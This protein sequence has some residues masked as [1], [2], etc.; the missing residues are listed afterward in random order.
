MSRHHSLE[1]NRRKQR[2]YRNNK[3]WRAEVE[4]MLTEEVKDALLDLPYPKIDDISHSM[5]TY[6]DWLLRNGHSYKARQIIDAI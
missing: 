6:V 3:M 5:L 4:A 1:Q 2:N